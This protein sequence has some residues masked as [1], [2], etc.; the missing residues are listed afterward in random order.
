VGIGLIIPTEVAIITMEAVEEELKTTIITIMVVAGV[1]EATT[2][3]M[4]PPLPLVF[5]LRVHILTEVVVSIIT[6]V[7][8]VV[9]RE[10]VI[11]KSNR[12]CNNSITISNINTNLM[13]ILTPTTTMEAEATRVMGA[14]ERLPLQTI[15]P[16]MV[17]SSLLIIIT[18]T[19]IR[20]INHNNRA[21]TTKIL[22]TTT[23][24]KERNEKNLK[25]HE[26]SVRSIKIFM[27]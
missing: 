3:I 11:S 18:N 2:R 4:A 19:E 5:K 14:T 23:T 8:M 10:I 20:P 15:A 6:V 9:A 22:E 1:L 27:K 16:I 21:A 17:N 12:Q 7:V 13:K 26:M 25:K 24:T